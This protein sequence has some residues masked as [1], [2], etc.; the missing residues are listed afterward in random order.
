MSNTFLQEL[1]AN[2]NEDGYVL[3]HGRK[4]Q[5]FEGCYWEWFGYLIEIG[6][7]PGTGDLR[8]QVHAL[9]EP[10]RTEFPGCLEVRLD[11]PFENRMGAVWN[12]PYFSEIE[13]SKIDLED[14]Y[15]HIPDTFLRKAWKVF[16]EWYYPFE[17]YCDEIGKTHAEPYVVSGT[18]CVDQ[19]RIVATGWLTYEGNHIREVRDESW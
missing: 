5:P 11:E 9:H 1:Q 18:M 13:I 4:N 2:L 19:I 16:D 10:G 3:I 8:V 6:H 17:W 14:V 12:K 7:E 15:K